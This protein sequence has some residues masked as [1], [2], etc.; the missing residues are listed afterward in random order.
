MRY[1]SATLPSV[2][3]S[4]ALAGRGDPAG[5]L[6]R[7]APRNDTLRGLLLLTVALLLA[8]A[9]RAQSVSWDPPGGSLGLNQMTELSL[10]FQDCSPDGDAV[11]LP[12]VDGLVF[13]T[14]TVGQQRSFSFGLGGNRGSST[15]TFTYPARPTR[16]GPVRIPAFEIETNKGRLKVAEAA[17]TVEDAPSAGSGGVTLSDLAIATLSTPKTNLWAG[18][19]FQVT[20]QLSIVRN[21][22]NGLDPAVQWQPAPIVAD[23]WSK[24]SLAE[25][26]VRGERRAVNTQTTRAYAKEPG[27]YTLGPTSQVVSLVVGTSGYGPFAAPIAEPRQL[28]TQPV[29]LNVRPLPP[30]PSGYTG[31]VGSFTFTSKIVPLSGAVNEPITWTIELA[32]TGNWPDIAGLPAREVSNDFSVVQPKSKRTMKDGALFEGVLSEDVVLVPTRTGAYTLGPVRFTYFDPQA[33]A[34]KTLS[35]DTVTVT[36]GGAAGQAATQPSIG[37]PRFMTPP[38]STPSLPELPAA[39]PP[40]PPEK[41]PRDPLP[42]GESGLAP[43][44]VRTLVWA[45][46]LSSVL[47][48]L[49]VWLVL[50]AVR[51]LRTDPQRRRREAKRRL[52]AILAELQSAMGPSTAA[53]NRL[54]DW[55]QETA[56]LWGLTHAAPGTP[57][58]HAGVA[59]RAR[60]AAAAWTK[61]WQ[62]ADRA[63]HGPVAPL[64]ADWLLRAEGALRAVRVPGWPPFSLFAAR[65]LLPMLLLG[66]VFLAPTDARADTTADAYKRGDFATAEKTWRATLDTTPRDWAARHNLGL[67]LAQQDRWAE[68]TAQW[69]SAFLH[70]PAADATRWNLALGLQHSG[71]APPELVEFSRAEGAH[72]LARL[73]SPGGWQRA[74]VGASLLLAAGLS[75]LLLN[76]YRHLGGWTKPVAL[77]ASLA[78]VLLAGTATFS[79]HTYGQLAHPDVALVWKASVLHSIPTDADAAQK[80][81]PLSAGSIAVVDR[82]FLGWSRLL[83]PAGQ[84]GWVR[85]DDLQMLYR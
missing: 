67:A 35:T 62:E 36:V 65:N 28:L 12:R 66:L 16:K 44:P 50:A 8:G 24:P 13:G 78:A 69:T 18:E 61:L 31:A 1:T 41:L 45:C 21:R 3:A 30:P 55:Q 32:G 46:L 4:P 39:V 68:A 10:V 5:L 53:S 73:A 23:D 70:H 49:I 27:R 19:V 79:L 58:V 72:G 43:W 85:T 34:Y 52:A 9:V 76:G 54:R 71:M 37:A 11:S 56:V 74:L 15:T 14:P 29:D 81:S 40:A 20:H 75:L 48:P 63:L 82:T 51:S 84:T 2:I 38:E 64:P 25:T 26:V 22:Y 7:L 17:F 47:C 59:A 42:T 60:D 6:R 83:F 77:L 80:T 33:G 57:L